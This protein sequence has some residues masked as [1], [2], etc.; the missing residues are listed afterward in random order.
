MAM[1]VM[2]VTPKPSA[3]KGREEVYR[4]S[5]CPRCLP[6]ESALHPISNIS[7]IAIAQIEINDSFQSK[8]VYGKRNDYYR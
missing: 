3:S 1:E 2:G 7:N 4:A 5:H 6:I 8:Q